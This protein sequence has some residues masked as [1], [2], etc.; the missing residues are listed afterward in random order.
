MID[1]TPVVL[2]IISIIT[3]IKQRPSKKY[4]HNKINIK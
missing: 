4:V 2:L 1:V 3:Y